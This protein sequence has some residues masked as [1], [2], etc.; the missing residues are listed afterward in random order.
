VQKFDK[1]TTADAVVG[2]GPF[3]M[4]SLQQNVAAEYVRNPDYWKP[5]LPYL[6]GVRTQQVQDEQTGYAAFQVGHIDIG[7]LTGALAKEYIAKQGAGY[8]PDWFKDI[9]IIYG[10]PNTKAKP[11]DDARVTRALRLLTDHDEFKT[12]WAEVFF[13]RGRHASS[14]CTALDDWDLT[15][16]EYAQKIFWKKPKDD[17]VKE[18]VQLLNAAG[19]SKDSP[20]SFELAGINPPQFTSA[21]TQLFQA[22][23]KRLGQGLV[24]AHIK[25]TDNPTALALQANETFTYGVWGLG[26]AATEPDAWL[27]QLYYSSGSRNRM[28]L[29]DAKLDDQIDKQRAIFD[30][31]QRKAA[32]K[33]IM[34]YLAD[35][36]PGVIGS[37]RYFLEAVKPKVQDYAP[38][39][40]INGRQY[41]W[42]WLNG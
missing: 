28:Q 3:I 36:S 18:A 15:E 19:Y 30:V 23:W 41:E 17:A 4:K 12:G 35:N 25:E 33:A 40:N 14:L 9:T 21:A 22:Q 31:A 6:D 5:G 24:D 27:S 2:T 39:F 11:M 34:G 10:T 7:R 1:L 38:E 42:I 20:L 32:V 26:G 29:K 13:G 16:Q 8:Q 37:N